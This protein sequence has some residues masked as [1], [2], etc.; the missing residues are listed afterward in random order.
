MAENENNEILTFDSDEEK[1]G[2][3]SSD[4]LYPY[5]VTNAEIEMQEAYF[6]IFEYTR[7][8]EKGHLILN[9]DFQ[10][11]L[12]WNKK[13]KSQYI[14]SILLNFPLPPIYLN[15][16]KDGTSQII[17]GLQRSTAIKDFIADGFALS[18]LNVLKKLN[19]L[20]FSKLE[21]VLQSRIE[22]KK[23]L[24]YILKPSVP[25]PIIYD[26]F[27]RINTGGTQLNRQEIRNCIFIGNSTRLLAE[28]ANDS[29]FKI[30]IDYGISP[31]RMK[32]REAVLRV[33]SF[34]LKDFRTDYMG[35]MSDFLEKVM[36]DINKMSVDDT[37]IIKKRFKRI[38]K[39]TNDFFGENNFRLP[40]L[41][42]R[43]RINLAV[44]DAICNFIDKQEDDYLNRNK[45]KIRDNYKKLIENPDFK[46]ALGGATGS[47]QS[48][49]KRFTLALEILGEG[50]HD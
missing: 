32:D 9:P 2:I 8:I 28:L 13:Q 23:L 40:T 25:L 22:D 24:C 19:G 38:M 15:Q 37:I 34:T 33:L 35:E 4:G 14:E 20:F 45:S 3:I 39:Y 21:S 47:I 7:K 41:E 42:T 1:D 17:D 43:G 11:H 18:E 44:M 46:Q 49:Q 48:V 31:K 16:R 27:N 12:V 30:A 36:V 26:L 5:D 6:S 29:D 10:R 50:T